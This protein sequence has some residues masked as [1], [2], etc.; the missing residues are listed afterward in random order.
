MQRAPSP[1]ITAGPSE[2]SAPPQPSA[3]PNKAPAVVVATSTPSADHADSSFAQWQAEAADDDAHHG[4][5]A[6]QAKTHKRRTSFE[7]AIDAGAGNVSLADAGAADSSFLLGLNAGAPSDSGA[8]QSSAADPLAAAFGVAAAEAGLSAP[9]A[10][11]ASVSTAGAS[12]PSAVAS[13]PVPV[14]TDPLSSNPGLA[15]RTYL[16][17]NTSVFPPSPPTPPLTSSAMPAHAVVQSGTSAPIA[18]EVPLPSPASSAMPAHGVVQSGATAPIAVKAPLPPHASLAATPAQSAALASPLVAAGEPARAATTD[19]LPIPPT[20][21]RPASGAPVPAAAVASVPAAVAPVPP[22]VAPTPVLKAAARVPKVTVP[23]LQANAAAAEALAARNAAEALA[24]KE[25]A[26]LADR[27]AAAAPLVA[28]AE[29]TVGQDGLRR[30]THIIDPK[31]D[32]Q[33]DED[34]DEEYKY[35][36]PWN[37]WQ[38]GFA[39]FG[40]ALLMLITLAAIGA[41]IVATHGTGLFALPF[42]AAGAPGVMGLLSTV[43][44]GLIPATAMVPT[45]AFI[46]TAVG[47]GVV[48]AGLAIASFFAIRGVRAEIKKAAWERDYA[49]LSDEDLPAE[50][51]RE[52]ASATVKITS[53]EVVNPLPAHTATRANPDA[54][55]GS[56]RNPES[57][58]AQLRGPLSTPAASR[59]RDTHARQNADRTDDAERLLSGD[60]SERPRPQQSTSYVPAPIRGLGRTLMSLFGPSSRDNLGPEGAIVAPATATGGAKQTAGGTEAATSSRYVPIM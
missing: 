33:L 25:A 6:D 2:S 37:R 19:Y 27:N 31:N 40:I 56:A 30:R 59:D 16:E 26:A 12:A 57:T 49:G 55:I 1:D 35:P 15:T 9:P 50:N 11:G 17:S 10:A 21:T 14:G 20:T 3:T 44:F 58:F 29:I 53:V 47:S 4:S 43:T 52:E 48:A 32:R 18:V 28:D 51:A 39:I 36:M 13:V 23:N 54:A 22:L 7:E 24:A 41:A 34:S 38:I 60:S 5:G 45:L 46:L 42:I 8:D